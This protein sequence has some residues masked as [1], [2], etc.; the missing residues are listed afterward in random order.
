MA[1]RDRIPVRVLRG[2]CAAALALACA[3]AGPAAG[4]ADV[5][6]TWREPDTGQLKISSVPPPWLRSAATASRGPAVHVYK[7]GK[8]VPPERV[9]AGGRIL[10]PPASQ[11]EQAQAAAVAK[12]PPLPELMKQ[13]NAT[14]ERLVEAALRVGPAPANEAFFALLDRY[15]ELGLQADAVDPAGAGTR[16]AERDLGMQR[17][18]AN[19]ERVLRQPGPRAAFQNQATAWFA[20]KSDL[21]AQKIVRCL[22]D[23]LC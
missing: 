15:L 21:A 20:D 23:G 6:Y 19:V 13:R 7:D 14:L 12:L 2:A 17:V 3:L 22:R 5:V 18:K 8:V 9:G 11:A 16:N 10:E 4:A 1:M